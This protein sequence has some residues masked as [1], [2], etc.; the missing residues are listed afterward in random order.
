MCG[1]DESARGARN[2]R[3][4][5]D[6][7][8]PSAR[9]TRTERISA[10]CVTD[11][12]VGT[13]LRSLTYRERNDSLDAQRKCPLIPRTREQRPTQDRPNLHLMMITYNAFVISDLQGLFKE[14]LRRRQRDITHEA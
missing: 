5:C 7:K 14:E 4:N 10:D 3:G 9:K 6:E 11:R 8:S 1:L 13:E 2:S 12:C